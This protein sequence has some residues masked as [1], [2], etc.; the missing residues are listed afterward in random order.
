MGLGDRVPHD[1]AA[2][3]ARKEDV[4]TNEKLQGKSPVKIIGD[5]VNPYG[6]GKETRI[7]D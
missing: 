3:C 4:K 6:T 7:Q 2:D 5:G 1:I